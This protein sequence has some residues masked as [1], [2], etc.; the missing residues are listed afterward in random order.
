MAGFIS[1]EEMEKLSPSR[2]G[3]I[4]DEEMAAQE[5][6]SNP[7]EASVMGMA[8]GASAGFLDELSG[9]VEAAGKAVGLKGLGGS[10]SDI[11]VDDDGPSLDWE[12]LRDAYRAGR[13]KKRGK[14]KQ[15]SDENPIS[16]GVGTLAGAVVSPANKILGG[17]GAIIDGALLGGANAL[18]HSEADS[19]GGMLADTALGVGAGGILGYGAQAAAPLLAKG[20]EKISTGSRNL[21]KSMAT[22]ALGAE[23]STVKKLGSEGVDEIGGYALDNGLLSSFGSADDM[24]ARNEAVISKAGDA[25]RAAYDAIDDQ[26]ASTFNPFTAATK[27]EDEVVGGLNRSFDDTQELIGAL[28]PHLS[29]ILSRGENNI[30]MREAQ[31]LI[32]SLGKKA[33]FDTSRNN[34][35]NDVAV[36]AYHALRKA[37]NEAAGEGADAVGIAGLRETIEGA[38]KT[39]SSG[40]KD[41]G[42]LDNKFAREQGNKLLGLTDT[43]AATEAVATAGG[44]VGMAVLGAKKGLER[45]GSQNAALGLDSISKFLQK[46]PQMMKAAQENPEAFQAMVSRLGANAGPEASAAMSLPRSAEQNDAA[47]NFRPT[48]KEQVLNRVRGSKYEQALQSAAQKG[49]ASYNAAYFVLRSRDPDFRKQIGDEN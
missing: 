49:D 2:P 41:K 15:I 17:G 10:F 36:N 8:Q 37:V 34:L 24:L 45:F 12:V 7:L 25:R 42:L 35:G 13:D 3:F 1:D 39:M 21:A 31:A 48:D 5:K 47:E 20:A 46:S 38:N 19:V 4:S 16:S 26:G 33:K 40:F 44:P 30:P 43:I 27:V 28:D 23:R 18:G 22:R 14:L 9:G 32:E 6:I 11:E 29:N